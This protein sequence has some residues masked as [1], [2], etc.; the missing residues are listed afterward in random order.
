M[1]KP[2]LLLLII[3]VVA[4]MG[5]RKTTD[6]LRSIPNWEPVSELP[7]QNIIGNILVDN[8]MY[9]LQEKSLS[10]WRPDGSVKNMP[11]DLSGENIVRLCPDYFVKVGLEQNDII[12]FFPLRNP[13]YPNVKSF[14][15]STADLGLGDNSFFATYLQ[16]FAIN[17]KNQLLVTTFFKDKNGSVLLLFDV[18]MS[19]NGSGDIE[20]VS[21]KRIN[22]SAAITFTF[23]YAFGD[24]FLA[25]SFLQDITYSVDASGNVQ[26][27]MK[28]AFTL[29]IQVEGTYYAETLNG[30]FK[31]E[32]AGISWTFVARN[33][34]SFSYL[35]DYI[36]L[37]PRQ[38]LIQNKDV[39]F[40]SFD[41]H[42]AAHNSSGI[43]ESTRL[44]KDSLN[45]NDL[46]ALHEWRGKVYA[47]T[48][49]GIF[50]RS[51]SDFFTPAL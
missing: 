36:A 44:D 14:K 22:V 9:V 42:L 11:H 23:N 46:L 50:T 48:Q 33:P 26:E 16:A 38:T 40:R 25:S 13:D 30:L 27:L 32:D 6:P 21:F 5:C 24:K 51:L 20:K 39:L 47:I 1:R 35:F 12:E 7:A 4:L 37:T 31:S 19:N 2:L 41:I 10:L 17:N 18:K 8:N 15:F 3:L 45:E 29:M 49:S 28:N 34:S 43:L